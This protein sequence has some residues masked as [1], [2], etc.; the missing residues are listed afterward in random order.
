VHAAVSENAPETRLPRPPALDRLFIL[1]GATH[2]ASGSLAREAVQRIEAALEEFSIDDRSFVV[3]TGGYRPAHLPGTVPHADLLAAELVRGGMSADK[4]LTMREPRNTVEEALF[5]L[6]LVAELKPAELII[7]TND[8]HL[9]RA[10]LIFETVLRPLPVYGRVA[11]SELPDDGYLARCRHEHAALLILER[12]GGVKVGDALFAFEKDQ[13]A[14]V[15]AL[16]EHFAKI[17][18]R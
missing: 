13:I 16:R 3:T 12:Q 9:P 2:D 7:L 14:R 11:L 17:P 6:A 18:A 15:A 10:L 1:L 4:I 8:F 5:T